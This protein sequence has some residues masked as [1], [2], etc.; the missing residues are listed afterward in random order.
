LT[1]NNNV[2]EKCQPY[3][4]GVRRVTS[5]A[6]D[7]HA[8]SQA[9]IDL[10]VKKHAAAAAAGASSSLPPL[11]S[12]DDGLLLEL[13]PTVVLTQSLCKVCAISADDV[14]AAASASC[15]IISGAPSTLAEVASSIEA[16]GEAC[17]VPRRG[18]KAR[19]AFEAQLA[20]VTAAVKLAG[21]QH[22]APSVMLMEW[23]DPVFDGGHWVPGMMRAVGCVPSLNDAEGT[24]STQRTWADVAAAD[25]DVILAGLDTT[26][27]VHVILQSKT[28]FH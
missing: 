6:I 28:R 2:S 21:S 20:Q 11:Y 8:T 7:P 4:A 27:H 24:R 1:H 23:L 15:D 10:E 25:P 18:K 3:S 22:P 19:D 12:V 16:I 14:S 26:F 9:D 17:G 5:S 13:A